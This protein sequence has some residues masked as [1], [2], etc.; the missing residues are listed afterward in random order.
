MEGRDVVEFLLKKGAK[1]LVVFDQK[2]APDLAS[3][4]KKFRPRGVK[5]FLSKDYLSSGLTGFDLIFR[6]PAFRLA[7]P[8]IKAAQKKG[9]VV[10]SATKLF[11]NLCPG[12]IIAVTGTK[13]K[14]TTATLI[15]QILKEA[16]KKVFLAGNIG[17]PMLFLLPKID[18][19]TWV[20]LELSS[21]QLQDLTLSPH[22]GVVLFI[23]SEHLDYHRSVEE[24][25]QAK[26]NLVSH[27]NKN[28]LAV[29][30]ADNPISA[31]FAHLTKARVFYFSRYR[32]TNA[33]YVNQGKIYL[34]N[35]VIGPTAKLK[36]LGEH[37]WDN[38]CAAITASALAGAH[39]EAIK[40]AVFAFKG[41]EHR[42][43]FVAK[44]KGV[45]FY[46]DSFSTTPETTIAALK[47]F[48]QSIILIA[49][50]SDKGADFTQLGREI[51]SSP[52][53]VLI[54][55][56]QMAERIQ[57]AAFK[58]GFRGKIIFR[59]QNMKEIVYQA[60]LASRPGEVVLL[61][62]ACASFDMFLNYKQ[63]GQEFKKNVETLQSHS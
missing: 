40:K 21:F 46:N 54:L 32:K 25:I 20:V 8:Q 28:D 56:G 61:S 17:R 18:K 52:V 44:I 41:L 4:L 37:N 10:S 3:E 50:G 16:G 1:N 15:Y 33:A 42:L 57:A 39:Q 13:G 60:F 24:Y 53:R 43:E 55:I 23:S 12:E 7:L 51:A 48:P 31:G 63:R 6:S 2:T 35:K 30:N 58:A 34:K 19:N 26:A 5:F 38:V 14:G 45:S 29:L 59:P 11:F 22:L 27:Q 36:L 49:G 9:V 62:P 47:A